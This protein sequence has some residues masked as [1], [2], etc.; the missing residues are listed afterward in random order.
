LCFLPEDFMATDKPC[1][2]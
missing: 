2:N 1:R